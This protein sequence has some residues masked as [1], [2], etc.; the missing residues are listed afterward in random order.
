LIKAELSTSLKNIYNPLDPNE[1]PMIEELAKGF[2]VTG[3]VTLVSNVKAAILGH[4]KEAE[5]KQMMGAYMMMGPAFMLGLNG[6]VNFN[7]DCFDEIKDHPMAAPALVSFS[8]LFES[9]LGFAPGEVVSGVN[10]KNPS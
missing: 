7:F 10:E 9:M 4:L 8:D 6:N 1:T 3:E 5:S 2:K